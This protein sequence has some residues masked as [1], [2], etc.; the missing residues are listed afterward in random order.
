M[1][2]PFYAKYLK[3]KMKYLTLKKE[4]M[5]GGLRLKIIRTISG[6]YPINIVEDKILNKRVIFSTINYNSTTKV[7]NVNYRLSQEEFTLPLNDNI[8]Y[9]IDLFDGRNFY[10]K[11]LEGFLDENVGKYLICDY[12]NTKEDKISDGQYGAITGTMENNN[13]TNDLGMDINLLNREIMEETGFT[14]DRVPKLDICNLRAVEKLRDI[15]GKRDIYLNVFTND[16]N[17]LAC[18]YDDNYGKRKC[19]SFIAL[20]E[21]EIIKM[22]GDNGNMNMVDNIGGLAFI[23]VESIREYYSLLF[24]PESREYRN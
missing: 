16:K 21:E 8:Q 20:T 12:Y 13:I 24:Y 5:T 6:K 18:C 4:K 3:Y 17:I 7:R 19:I 1:E 15:R 11:Y 14:G 10:V 22:Y 2:E 9:I 23:P